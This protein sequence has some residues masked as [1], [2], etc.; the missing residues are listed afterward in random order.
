VSDGE[1]ASHCG[2]RGSELAGVRRVHEWART[3][4]E[5]HRLATVRACTPRRCAKDRAFP[6]GFRG[7]LRVRVPSTPPCLKRPFGR[8]TIVRASVISALVHF[9]R[10]RPAGSCGFVDS[11]RKDR[12]PSTPPCSLPLADEPS[13]GPLPILHSVRWLR[14][15]RLVRRQRAPCRIGRVR[16]TPPTCPVYRTCGHQGRRVRRCPRYRWLDSLLE[17]ARLHGFRR[18]RRTLG[19]NSYCRLGA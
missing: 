10:T 14:T 17:L 5:R 2:D 13:S 6:D 18:R 7:V 15:R 19:T 11:C 4:S 16:S 12:V 1:R 8:Q 9:A 3:C